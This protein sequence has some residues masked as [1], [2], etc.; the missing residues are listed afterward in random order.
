MSLPT[1]DLREGPGGPPIILGEQ[2]KSQKEEKLAGQAKQPSLPAF[3]AQG[4]DPPLLLI[5]STQATTFPRLTW[6]A[7]FHNKTSRRTS[8]LLLFNSISLTW[9]EL[10]RWIGVVNG[11]LWLNFS[12]V[13]VIV[14]PSLQ[15]QPSVHSHYWGVYRAAEVASYTITPTT[16]RVSQQLLFTQICYIQ[17]DKLHKLNGFDSQLITSAF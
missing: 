4:L 5:R 12:W 13:E 10:M 14:F 9:I 7:F 6:R 15:T 17:Q 2:R 11:W 3:L 16:P 8:S 1:A